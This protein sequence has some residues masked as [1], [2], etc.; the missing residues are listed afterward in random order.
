MFSVVLCYKTDRKKNLYKTEKH[1]FSPMVHS[2]EQHLSSSIWVSE[3]ECE[4]L[5]QAQWVEWQGG[6]PEAKSTIV[7]IKSFESQEKQIYSPILTTRARTHT[8]AEGL[9][10]EQ[11]VWVRVESQ[12]RWEHIRMK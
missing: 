1:Q 12:G 9:G 5:K 10:Q 6:L 4:G 7:F 11:K 8:G 3:P 2:T